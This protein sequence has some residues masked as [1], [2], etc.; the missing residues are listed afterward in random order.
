MT[1]A[2]VLPGLPFSLLSSSAG[3]WVVD[4][5]TGTLAATTTPR[6]D[7]FIDPASVAGPAATPVLDALTLLGAPPEGDFADG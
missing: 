1:T 6:S 7:I 2:H 4:P 3:R 5:E